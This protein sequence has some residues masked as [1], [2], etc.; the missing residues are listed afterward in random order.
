MRTNV[1]IDGFNLYYGALR[2]TAYKW[3]DVRRMCE[4]ILPRNQI[5]QIKYFTA[6]VSPQTGDRSQ[7]IRQDLYLRALGTVPGVSIHYGHFLVHNVHRRLANP[8]PGTN[9]YVEIV[10]IEE[11]GSDVNLAAH[12]LHDGHQGL[13]DAAVVVSNDSDLVTPILMVKQDLGFPVGVLNPH[14][15]TANAI[16]DSASFIRPIRTGVLADS[17][18]PAT[19]ADGSGTIT[20]PHVW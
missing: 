7:A 9:P 2:K 3:L 10:K 1:Y 17:Q 19:L 20:R 15:R 18:L 11:K 12:L 5:A 16:R 8:P 6:R 13:Y 4:K 14:R